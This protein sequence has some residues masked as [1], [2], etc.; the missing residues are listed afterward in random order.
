MK[1]VRVHVSGTGK[2][3]LSDL[4]E[5]D[6]EQSLRDP[7]TFRLMGKRH[8]SKIMTILGVIMDGIVIACSALS[9]ERESFLTASGSSYCKWSVFCV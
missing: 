5:Y 7:F 9:P 6:F 3:V 1:S 2:N 8:P 4:K